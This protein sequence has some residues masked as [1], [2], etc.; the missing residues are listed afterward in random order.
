MGRDRVRAAAAPDDLVGVD[1][2]DRPGFEAGGD[3]FEGGDLD[4]LTVTRRL[5]RPQREQGADRAVERGEVP[6]LV[7]RCG[8]RRG[9]RPPDLGHQPAGRTDDQVRR[10]PTSPWTCRPERR[11]EDVDQSV[12]DRLVR[13]QAQAVGRRPLQH[14]VGAVEQLAKPRLITA[15]VERER[16]L[17]GVVVGEGG[18][19]GERAGR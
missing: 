14:D 4:A 2:R 18:T 13:Q 6:C 7:G 3:A 5:S 11:E 12:V 16:S 19:A 8:L 15:R 9:V 17:A 10:V 1:V